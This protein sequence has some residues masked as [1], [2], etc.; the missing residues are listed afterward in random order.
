MARAQGEVPEDW[1]TLN[2]TL[3]VLKFRWM[4]VPGSVSGT[5]N[6]TLV[7]LKS[8]VGAGAKVGVPALNRTLVVLK[9]V[10]RAMPEATV[11]DSESHPCGIEIAGHRAGHSRP[12]GL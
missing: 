8:N 12:A 6:R 4:V 7:V 3:V 2:R 11:S 5:L 1:Q 10:E 9:Y